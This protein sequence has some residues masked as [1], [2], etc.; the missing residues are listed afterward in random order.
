V[1]ELLL[2]RGEEALHH[3]VVPAVARRR[4]H[5]SDEIT[6]GAGYAEAMEIKGAPR[7]HRN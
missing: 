2:E 5:R 3:R 4:P 1:D 7:F 6:G